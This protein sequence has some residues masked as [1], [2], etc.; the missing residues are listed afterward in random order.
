MLMAGAADGL[1]LS[2]A[3]M[4]GE[5][6]ATT[7]SNNLPEDFER[8]IDLMADGR[9]VVAPMITHTFDLTDAV[10]AFDVAQ[11]KH[12]TGAIKVIIHP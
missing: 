11:R 3:A 6:V 7:S 2:T 4:A 9:V 8:G 12:E 10:E 5:R 1:Q